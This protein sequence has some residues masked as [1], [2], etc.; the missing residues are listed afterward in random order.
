MVIERVSNSEFRPS[1]KTPNTYILRSI[2]LKEINTSPCARTALPGYAHFISHSAVPKQETNESYPLLPAFAHHT[3]HAHHTRTLAACV[4]DV[5]Q[6][7]FGSL[8]LV[9]AS[10]FVHQQINQVKS[11]QI[12]VVEV[13]GKRVLGPLLVG[14]ELVP[15]H[16]HMSSVQPQPLHDV[17]AVQPTRAP[18]QAR[19]WSFVSYGGF[20]HWHCVGVGVGSAKD[21]PGRGR[22]SGKREKATNISQPA[23]HRGDQSVTLHF[24]EQ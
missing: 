14:H 13:I 16:S 7:L 1:R 2:I 19:F 8:V 18:L 23:S 10:R 4:T 24:R 9:C 15:R 3:P 11:L 20:R 12:L 6:L 21:G 5:R 17:Q 22:P